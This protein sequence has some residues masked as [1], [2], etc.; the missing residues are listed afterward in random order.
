MSFYQR[1]ELLEPLPS[2]DVKMFKG[3][4]IATGQPVV[5]HLM[6]AGRTPENEALL[7]QVAKL[8]PPF[9]S[10]VRDVGEH[11]GTPYVV[12]DVLPGGIGL[13]E[14]VRT[15]V[16]A[17][18]RV[19]APPPP[20]PP[21]VQAPPP[22]QATPP[23]P[24]AFTRVGMWRVPAQPDPQK[25]AP[26][27]PKPAADEFDRMFGPPAAEAASTAVFPAPATPAAGQ[28]PP[29]PA[30]QEPGEFTRLFQGKPPAP[31]APAT[32]PAPPSS[33]APGARRVYP[34]VPGETGRPRARAAPARAA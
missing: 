9:A 28:A 3:R 31:A 15:A 26:E 30:A 29:A 20:P 8:A 19:P 18:P 24:A 6:V 5:A 1:F 12:T 13:R 16:A 11:E 4:E 21:P 7:A 10:H 33:P 25:P 27:A 17:T 32:P 2:Q 14:Y 23:D 34:A 22:P